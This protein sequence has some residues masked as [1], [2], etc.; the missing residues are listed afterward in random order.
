MVDVF[1]D[2]EKVTVESS[3]AGFVAFSRAELPLLFKHSGIHYAAGYCGSGTVWAP[4]FGK[5]VAEKI[6]ATRNGDTSPVS[7]FFCDPPSPLPLY[8]GKPWFLPAAM[9][10]EGMKDKMQG[11]H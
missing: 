7:A 9:V 3:W 6:L 2:L 10:W 11:R 5:L 1:P 4:W 8:N